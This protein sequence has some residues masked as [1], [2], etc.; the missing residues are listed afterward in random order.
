MHIAAH[1]TIQRHRLAPGDRRQNPNR[2]CPDM[3]VKVKVKFSTD[4]LQTESRVSYN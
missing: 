4:T 1:L 3:S 2:N